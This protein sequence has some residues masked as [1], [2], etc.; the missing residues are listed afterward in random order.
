MKQLKDKK[1]RWCEQLFIPATSLQIV[2]T[3]QCALSYS[4]KKK[5]IDRLKETRA[6]RKATK[7]KD[8]QYWIKKAQAAFNAYIRARDTGLPCISCG[9]PDGKGKRNAGHYRPAGIN[10]ALR[11]HEQ[12]CNGQ[13]ERC[14]TSL[15]GNV[16]MYRDGLIRKIGAEAVEWLDNNHETKRWEISELKNIEATY[17]AKLKAMQST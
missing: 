7:D 11:F 16:L 6:M 13:C 17:K 9:C 2:C 15:S 5:E 4:R 12:N 10:T 14:N 1:C 8:R 3:P